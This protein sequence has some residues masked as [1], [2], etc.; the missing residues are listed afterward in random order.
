MQVEL[1]PQAGRA[2]V[3]MDGVIGSG[4]EALQAMR[5]QLL[6]QAQQS[7]VRLDDVTGSLADTA[8]HIRRDPG[9]LLRG[10]RRTPGPGE[11]Q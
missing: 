5:T 9:V 3:H 1:L 6:P 7:L 4:Q 11:A 8:E 2:F 10:P